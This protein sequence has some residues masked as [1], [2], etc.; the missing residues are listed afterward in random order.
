MKRKLRY[1]TLLLPLSEIIS[2][3][4]LQQPLGSTCFAEQLLP[5]FPY[6]SIVH[7][8][9]S[10]LITYSI[11]V[12]MFLSFAKP[13]L[14]P[15]PVINSWITI[16]SRQSSRMK[17]LPKRGWQKKKSLQIKVKEWNTREI[18]HKSQAPHPFRQYL[19]ETNWKDLFTFPISDL[20]LGHVKRGD[21][22]CQ[23]TGHLYCV[24]W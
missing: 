18:I 20:F 23:L 8:K 19:G 21:V 2:L 5:A 3:R 14:P 12:F 11:R 16:A 9:T 7:F 10:I 4:K 15:S 13:T 6:N 17:L 22:T 1:L 24:I